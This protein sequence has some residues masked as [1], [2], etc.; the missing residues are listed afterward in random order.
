[1]KLIFKKNSGLKARTSAYG[2]EK[3]N[4]N[5]YYFVF[6]NFFF[7]IAGLWRAGY[8][9]SRSNHF[10]QQLASAQKRKSGTHTKRHV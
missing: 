6:I 9:S 3:I 5:K 2:P 8:F 10:K 4:F 1:M 7:L